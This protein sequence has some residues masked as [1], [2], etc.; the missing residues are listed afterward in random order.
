MM[1]HDFY[2]QYKVEN[3]QDVDQLTIGSGKYNDIT[4]VY[5]RILLL[6]TAYPNSLNYARSGNRTISSGLKA[7]LHSS[8]LYDQHISCRLEEMK[9]LGMDP[10]ADI[11]LLPKGSWILEF[12]IELEK[13]FLSR[14]DVPFYIIDNPVKKDIVFSI[15]VT[16]AT[17]WKGNL[18]WAMMKKWLESRKNNPREFAEIRFRHTLLF[19][20]EKGWESIPKGWTEYLDRM[21]PDAKEIYRKKLIEKF[22]DYAKA[23]DIHVQGMLYFYPTFWNKAELMIINPHDRKTKT[24]KNPIYFEIVPEGAKGMFRLLY[25]PYHWLGSNN[26]ELRNKI[27]EDLPQIITGIKA[28]IFEYGFSAKKTV[29]FGKAKNNLRFGRLEIKGFLS[30]RK[31]SNFEELENIWGV[32]DEHS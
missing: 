15:P 4:D 28:M 31:F 19:G 30:A 13:P 1:C 5:Q 18:R 8:K 10:E 16:L 21:C 24:G 26:E 2:A 32:E 11:A 20:T 14:D 17:T 3:E 23:E 9:T 29:G 27:Q 6:S 22:G 7:I 25:V 12:Q